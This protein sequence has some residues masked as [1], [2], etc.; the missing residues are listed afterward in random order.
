MI[1]GHK[2]RSWLFYYFIYS[3]GFSSFLAAV[4]Q[5]DVTASQNLFMYNQGGNGQA[6]INDLF[7]HL[8]IQTCCPFVE[9]WT[10]AALSTCVE[11]NPEVYLSNTSFICETLPVGIVVRNRVVSE[12]HLIVP[13]GCWRD[14]IGLWT[15]CSCSRK[16]RIS[17]QACVFC[18]TTIVYIPYY[19]YLQRVSYICCLSCSRIKCF[20]Q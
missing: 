15:F 1:K 13:Y 16:W 8:D 9:E 18:H 12:Y 19:I 14:C 6:M 5:T 2:F 4:V 17:P 3:C 7:C 10:G 20:T 11:N